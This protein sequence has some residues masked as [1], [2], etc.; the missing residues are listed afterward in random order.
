M[1]DDKKPIYKKWWF[2][3]GVIVLIIIIWPK[4]NKA[5]NNQN[6]AGITATPSDS[7]IKG[8]KTPAATATATP[9]STIKAG[10]HKIGTDVP[11]GEY[12]IF[13]ES[14]TLSYYQVTKD[15]SGSLESIITNDNFT[16]TRYITVS[17]G[18]YIE[19]R[20][21]SMISVDKAPVLGPTDGKY[22]EGMYKVG[23]DIK[24]GEYKLVPTAAVSS[25]VEVAKDSK[26]TIESIVT[27]DNFTAEKYITIKEG[28][29]IKLVGCSMAAK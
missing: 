6:L 29:Y 11:A 17:D 12:I 22:K 3:L 2:W 4:G 9:S 19:M 5:P 23:R 13:S 14:D 8:T 18:Q 20:D 1:S 16:G 21:S 28:Q 27:N 15:S 7:I 26:G 25:Y 10:M 24:A